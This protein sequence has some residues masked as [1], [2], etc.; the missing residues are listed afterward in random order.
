MEN[1]KQYV[2]DA[3]KAW[4]D[5]KAEVEAELT[6]QERRVNRASETRLR[7]LLRDVRERVYVPYRDA[8]L[9]DS[10]KEEVTQ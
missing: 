1:V 9:A 3:R 10:K 2:V 7:G 5:L 6:K 4:E 8:S